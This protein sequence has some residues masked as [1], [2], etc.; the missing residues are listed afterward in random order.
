M[1]D[2]DRNKSIVTAFYDAFSAGDVER[3]DDLLSPDFVNHPADPGRLNDRS[4]FKDGVRDFHA[5][6]DGFRIRRDAL[7]AEGDLVVCRITMTGRHVAALGD[8][9]PSGADVTFHG[10]D[11]HRIADGLIAKTWHFER[12]GDG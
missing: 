3:F 5:A 12:F 8:W 6:F 11:M 10:M 9:Q 2:L 4:G 1:T 7:V